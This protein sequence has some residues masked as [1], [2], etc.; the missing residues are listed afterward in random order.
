M[1]SLLVMFAALAGD[2]ALAAPVYVVT[3]TVER[4][5]I[6]EEADLEVRAVDDGS[7][8]AALAS[9]QIVGREATR[10]L[11]V[12]RVVRSGDVAAPLMVRKGQPVTILVAR[13]GLSIA[14]QGRA[15]SSGNRG[16]LVRVQS[17][18]S[19][20]LI[21]ASVTGPGTVAVALAPSLP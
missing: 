2:I 10:R 8:R 3:Q 21:E 13:G 11:E 14:A 6:V 18:A 4:G 19:R 20:S 12:G 16:A 17:A 1:R 7:A 9:D 5:A 15:L